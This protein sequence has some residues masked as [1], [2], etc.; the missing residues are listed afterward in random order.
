MVYIGKREYKL[1]GMIM[2][3]MAADT[4][5]ELHLMASKLG[6]DSRHFQN[7]EG[8]PHYDLCKSRKL[9]GIQK[10]GCK[11]VDDRELILLYRAQAEQKK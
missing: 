9:I 8:K 4:L 2:S 6:I 10:Y 5:D 7:K 3:H 1:G 11:L